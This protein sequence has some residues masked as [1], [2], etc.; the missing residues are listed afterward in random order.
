MEGARG[1]TLFLD[2][3]EP[4]PPRL[5]QGLDPPLKCTVFK[6]QQLNFKDQDVFSTFSLLTNQN[7]RFPYH[8]I[9]F[10]E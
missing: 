7:E 9:Y 5:S 4:P 3:T 2:Q 10:K 8:F 1:S 6:I